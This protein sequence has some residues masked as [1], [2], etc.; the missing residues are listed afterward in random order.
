VIKESS[1]GNK[2]SLPLPLREKYMHAAG[3]QQFPSP[4]MII[5]Q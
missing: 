5:T 2:A 4:Q 3:M 1:N